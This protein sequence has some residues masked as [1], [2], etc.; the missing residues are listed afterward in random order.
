M[1]L[2]K[3]TEVF[4]QQDIEQLML[5]VGCDAPLWCSHS[6]EEFCWCTGALAGLL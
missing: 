1:P 5:P 2:V 4:R 6:S 3:E